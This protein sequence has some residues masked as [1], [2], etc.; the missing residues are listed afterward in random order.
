MMKKGGL[1]RPQPSPTAHAGALNSDACMN[2][3]NQRVM[4]NVK[5]KPMWC[6]EDVIEMQIRCRPL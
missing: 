6:E 1:L 2:H 5:D 4:T 3:S